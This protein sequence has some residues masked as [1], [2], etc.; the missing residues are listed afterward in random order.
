VK[1]KLNTTSIQ[2]E[3]REF[4]NKGV[5]QKA[6]KSTSDTEKTSA[7]GGRSGREA[8]AVSNTELAIGAAGGGGGGT[9]GQEREKTED[10]F[11]VAIPETRTVSHTSAGD[12]T[13]VSATV[14][15]PLSYMNLLY[16]SQNAST[17]TPTYVQLK[18]LIEEESA[19]FCHQV[20]YCVGLASP[21]MVAFDVYPDE[22]PL[23]S[24]PPLASAS[25]GGLS[26]LVGG[27]AKEIALGTLAVMS[28]FMASMMVRKASPTPIPAIA[29]A[30]ARSESDR[31][32]GPFTFA[33]EDLAGEATGSEGLL[34]G[35]ELNEETV[36]AGRM[37][38]QVSSMV[39]ENPD[40]AAALMKRWLSR[41]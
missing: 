27:H 29:A 17:Q 10:T 37:V 36:K 1:M 19:K 34:D 25:T 14:R 40:A 7:P 9:G 22:M 11:T 31:K 28:L 8:G 6:T 30:S 33:G 41:A 16:R 26:L 21:E 38:E 20:A 3:K 32:K 15:V 18:P 4:D 5:I 2:T 13:P 23:L 35:L 12:A 24:S 39:R